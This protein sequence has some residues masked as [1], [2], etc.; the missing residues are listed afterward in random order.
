MSVEP[1]TATSDEPRDWRQLAEERG[2]ALADADKACQAWLN[3]AQM[4]EEWADQL[5][6]VRLWLQEQLLVQ[7]E[8]LHEAHQQKENLL[9]ELAPLRAQSAT[10]NTAPVHTH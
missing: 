8:E 9:A 7:S 10:A 4:A 5:G 2:R 1:W 3:T 6:K